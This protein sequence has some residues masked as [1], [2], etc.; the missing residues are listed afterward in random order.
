MPFRESMMA[1]Q[2]RGFL[3]SAW[4]VLSDAVGHLNADD[5]WAMASNVALTWLMALFPFLIFVAAVAGTIGDAGLAGRVAEMLFQTWPAGVAGPI[6]DEVT[7]VLR[8]A[9]GGLLTVSAA[10]ALFLAT[11]GVEAV[12]TAL[13]RAYRVVDR[14]SFFWLRL[15]SLLFVLVGTVVILLL[16]GVIVSTTALR[17]PEPFDYLVRTVGTSVTSVLLVGVLFSAHLWLPAGR[18][19]WQ[20]LWP[21]IVATLVLWALSA[22]IFAYYL[23][24]FANYAATYAGLAGVVTAI[25]FLYIVSVV[26]IFGAE[27]NAAICRLRERKI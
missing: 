4:I 5:G 26:L 14:R 25:F 16:A 10:V 21:G 13:N 11:S 22:W 8:P 27:F 23:R 6:A 9:H 15:Q 3:R 1:E 17:L 2:D 24:S 19:P 18:P 12:R 20:Q 7:R